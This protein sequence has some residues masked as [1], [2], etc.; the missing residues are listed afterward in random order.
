MEN[1]VEI[2]EKRMYY[3]VKNALKSQSKMSVRAMRR[4]TE[5]LLYPF[6]TFEN[7]P[8]LIARP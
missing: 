3:K 7:V 4:S 1:G 2:E 6:S 5:G 8:A